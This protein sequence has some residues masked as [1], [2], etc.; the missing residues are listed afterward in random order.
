MN[1][2]PRSVRIFLRA[3]GALNR[4][5][6]QLASY[7]LFESGFTRELI[8]LGYRDAMNRRHEIEAFLAG[9]PLDSPARVTGWRDLAQEYT[10][11][12]TMQQLSGKEQGS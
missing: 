7:L 5:G 6:M 11:K 1:Q 2:L 4:G 8:D 9:E 3:L 12:F 10:G